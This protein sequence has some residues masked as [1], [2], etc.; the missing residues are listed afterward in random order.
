MVEILVALSGVI[1]SGHRRLS[2]AADSILDQM[3]EVKG[4]PG[5]GKS[6]GPN[7]VDCGYVFCFVLL[8]VFVAWFAARCCGLSFW[9]YVSSVERE[10]DRDVI[11]RCPESMD[12]RCFNLISWHGCLE[13]MDY[14]CFKLTFC[15]GYRGILACGTVCTK[16]RDCAVNYGVFY[17]C[18]AVAALHLNVA[19]AENVG[20]NES[21]DVPLKVS[22]RCTKYQR[23]VDVHRIAVPALKLRRKRVKRLSSFRE[24]HYEHKRCVRN[25]Y[26]LDSLICFI[27]CVVMSTSCATCHFKIKN[28]ND[29]EDDAT[30]NI[31][32]QISMSDTSAFE[33]SV[34]IDDTCGVCSEVFEYQQV[35]T[36]QEADI[37]SDDATSVCSSRQSVMN[38]AGGGNLSMSDG[39]FGVW[40]GEYQCCNEK[41][42]HEAMGEG[43]E[44]DV[45]FVESSGSENSDG[46]NAMDD[47]MDG[48]RR[49]ARDPTYAHGEDTFCESGYSDDND[50][51]KHSF[52]VRGPRRAS[53]LFPND[54]KKLLQVSRGVCA[55]R[56]VSAQELSFM[57]DALK[58]E[59]DFVHRDLFDALCVAFPDL[60]QL[61]RLL[62]L[63]WVKD[64]K[65]WAEVKDMLRACDDSAVK[66][67]VIED[68]VLVFVSLCQQYVVFENYPSDATRRKYLEMGGFT[69]GS[70]SGHGCN[71][72]VDSLLHLFLNLKFLN[73]PSAGV[74]VA[75]WRH[76]ICELV[77]K[78]LCGHEDV[79]LR[80]RQRNDL[81][82]VMSV[83]DEV[84]ARAYLEHQKHSDAI[85][86]Y[87]VKHLGLQNVN[88]VRCFRVIV[89]S[90]CDGEVVNPY[91]DVVHINFP[92]G[93]CIPPQDL[94]LYNNTG[95]SS[96]GL[97][98]DPIMKSTRES[99]RAQK[100]DGRAEEKRGM[101][102]VGR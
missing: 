5:T 52:G 101:A 76:E 89:F 17:I 90:R 25:A 91:E 88:Y 40:I 20:A 61:H 60:Q 65:G 16:M 66:R 49:H 84:H 45:L 44:D 99:A 14:R 30:S 79:R 46:E 81:N 86:R 15:R 1:G 71:C 63:G 67:C 37:L 87:L 83:S 70:G 55:V 27:L 64:W 51:A 41:A 28:R 98:Y 35:Q 57:L 6:S 69:F 11:G 22:D 4:K 21:D 53:V 72:L 24:R 34:Y 29:D 18:N 80:P 54:C 62:Q 3:E 50:D 47:V 26:E 8:F 78:H 19:V 94:L 32:N 58:C 85:V 39:E 73:G 36:V 77:R 48:V 31:A 82:A 23:Q 102:R 33:G 100:G 7:P 56:E 42:T 92:G 96:S 74:S 13:S 97:H 59:A 93:E 68:F 75:K 9:K 10:E 95:T 12:Y 38:D 2:Q 43:V